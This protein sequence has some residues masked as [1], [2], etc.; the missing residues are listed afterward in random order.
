MFCLEQRVEVSKALVSFV[1]RQGRL[2]VIETK[3][4]FDVGLEVKCNAHEGGLH[5][6]R[7]QVLQ[8]FVVGS[9]PK[10]HVVLRG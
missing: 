9:A 6:K 3:G 2:G 4:H 7:L 5:Q 10:E 1:L 8:L